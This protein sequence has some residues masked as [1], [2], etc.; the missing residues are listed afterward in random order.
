MRVMW[1][2]VMTL[3][4]AT[5]AAPA[6]RQDKVLEEFSAILSNISNVG[7][8]GLTPLTI[9]ITRWTGDEENERLLGTLREKGQSAFLNALLDAKSVGYIMT[10]TSL[11]YDFF[12]ARQSVDK[13]GGRHI[14]L[15][16][17]RPMTPMERASAARSRDYPF[18]VIDLRLDKEGEGEG[19]L[20]QLVQLR[21]LGDILGIENLATGPM[22]LSEVKKVK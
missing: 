6:A 22:K 19:T 21:L 1:L 16:S 14:M 9:R 15:I 12:Y 20:S 8:T 11:R 4:L 17:D 7:G 3:V 13:E 2:S 18:T 5:A 10:P